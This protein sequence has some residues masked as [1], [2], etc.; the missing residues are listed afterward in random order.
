MNTLHSK[1]GLVAMALA[2][3]VA[4]Y[5]GCNQNS[6]ASAET[7]FTS[8]S[9]SGGEPAFAEATALQGLATPTSG[10]QWDGTASTTI[11]FDGSQITVSGPGAA[12][13]NNTITITKGGNY[14]LSGDLADGQ[15]VINAGKDE[16]VRL[17]LDGASL[18]SS[19]SAP[20]Y[21][22]QCSQLILTL[23]GQSINEISD[24]SSLSASNAGTEPGAAVFSK[25]NLAIEG[26]GSLIVTANRSN[27]IG[28]GESLFLSGGNI[29]ITA[30]EGGLYSGGQ[31]TVTGGELII[32]TDT[33]GLEAAGDLSVSG[34][35]IQ[36]TAGGGSQSTAD[37]FPLSCRG[38]FVGGDLSVS[39]G[40]GRIDSA[41]DGVIS[42]CGV[43]IRDAVLSLSTNG[44]GICAGE[45]LI[46]SGGSRISVSSGS[47]GLEGGDVRLLEDAVLELDAGAVGISAGITDEDTSS[48][49]L[50]IQGGSHS[51]HAQQT[52]FSTQNGAIL[53]GGYVELYSP[54]LWNGGLDI[55]SG[56]LLAAG[57]TEELPTPGPD[58]RQPCLLLCF[59][60]LRQ[61]NEPI[62]LE[63]EGT[64]A[65]SFT[66]SE[67][68][69]SI[70]ISTPGLTKGE[71]YTITSQEATV[72]DVT[73]SH[74]VTGINDAGQ[75]LEHAEGSFSASE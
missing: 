31:T 50:H 54:T 46:L 43:V 39:G 49:R 70:V 2:L 63:L 62:A 73:L 30:P 56:T 10:P 8:S 20:I 9:A 61:K 23:A 34:G 69:R 55:L 17:V 67:A 22:I 40:T 75:T 6:H 7:A 74:V 44:K 45:N 28:A 37:A 47:N 58:S 5:T 48:G 15:V 51:I 4:S 60:A 12:V 65:A 26:P 11:V 13:H 38:V 68:Y 18:F 41:G 32:Y 53:K 19:T 24:A 66:P 14:R 21:A 71:T 3:T 16:D 27:G 52:A 29:E 1:A 35:S 42:Q 57:S 36:I 59:S 72:T 25:G 33:E 64:V